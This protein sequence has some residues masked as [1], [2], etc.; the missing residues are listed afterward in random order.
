MVLSY[1][2]VFVRDANL[3]THSSKWQPRSKKL[4]FSLPRKSENSHGYESV[5]PGWVLCGKF[6]C[7]VL[8]RVRSSHKRVLVGMDLPEESQIHFEII[9]NSR[10]R[11]RTPLC[12]CLTFN[13]HHASVCLRLKKWF[14]WVRSD[15]FRFRR[16][17]HDFGR[18][19]L[20]N[21][22][23]SHPTPE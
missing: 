11:F 15:T 13:G 6:F 4:L 18:S 23:N 19:N 17:I 3:F 16:G 5:I 14:K 12:L 20:T 22:H 7:C 2:P 10:L 21:A 9:A 1:T 8:R